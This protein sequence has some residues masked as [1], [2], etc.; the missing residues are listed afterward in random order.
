MHQNRFIRA[1]LIQ[2]GSNSPQL[3][4]KLCI[5][6][7][8]P[9]SLLRVCFIL[10]IVFAS[11]TIA[12]VRNVT[13]QASFPAQLNKSFVPTTISIGGT[14]VF[15]VTIFNPNTFQLTNAAWLD[16]LPPGLTIAN[17]PNATTDCAGGTVT[18]APGGS[19]LQLS[20]GTVPPQVSVTPGQCSVIVNVT[21][22]TPGNH[23]NT[24]PAGA[25]TSTGNGNPIT[26]TTPASATLTV[27]TVIAP[28][29]NK[30]FE[31]LT[32]MFVGQTTNLR[33][34]I[35]NVDPL[36][37][38]TNVSVT[39]NLP[40]GLTVAGPPTLSGCGGGTATTTATT[41]TLN[42]ATIAPNTT[43]DILVP[44]TSNTAGI[45]DNTIPA[46]AVTTQQGVTNANPADA[47]LNVQNVE[48]TK[49][50][51]PP[52]VL[53]GNTTTLTITLSNPT[54]TPYTGVAIT[55][56]LPA[57]VVVA[58]P[59]APSTTCG[60][61]TVSAVNGTGSVSLSGGTIPPG[62]PAA[63]GTCTVTVTV[64]VMTPGGHNNVIPAGALTTNQGAT[65]VL[66]AIEDV[67]GQATGTGAVGNKSFDPPT[68]AAGGTS[69]L[70]IT[71]TSPPDSALTNLA[72]TDNL[73]ANVTVAAFP[74]SPAPSTTCGGTVTAV[75]G[76]TTIS[77]SG[78]SMAANASC[79]IEVF[80][81]SSTPGI[82]TNTIPAGGITNAEDRSNTTPFSSDLE[83]TSGV[84]VDKV[85]TPATIGAGGTSVL[86]I[87]ITNMNT[88]PLTN[89]SIT[90]P[91]PTAGGRT[92]TVGNPANASTTCGAG[93]V[94]A[95]PGTQTVTLNGGTVPAQAGGVPGTCTISVNVVG[96]GPDGAIQNTIP[97]NSLTNAQGISN[98]QPAQATMNIAPLSIGVVKEFLPL[99]VFGG[100]AST[101]T[102]TLINPTATTLIGAAFTDTMPAG[103]IVATPLVTGTT[104][105]SGVVTA[106]V[107]AG[108]F[109]FS[110][111]NLPGG[112]ACTI[113]ISITMTVNGNLTNTIP[114]GG[115]TTLNG[116]SNPQAAAAS[117]TNLPGVSL[118]KAFTPNAIPIGG[119]SA[120]VL[121]IRNTNGFPLTDLNVTDTL[122]A[123]L[124]IAPT[125]G[126]VNTCAGTVTANPGGS[127]IQLTG[128]TV[129]IGLTCA[130][131]ANITGTTASAFTN[132]VPPGGLTSAEG[133]T[134]TT[135]ATDILT[136]GNIT[137]TPSLTPTVTPPGGSG[138]GSGSGG[139]GAGG[140]ANLQPPATVTPLP[141]P[142]PDPILADP[143]ISKTGDPSLAIPGDI[144]NWDIAVTNRGTGPAVNFVVNETLPGVLQFMS[145]SADQGTFNVNG[146]TI[147]FSVGTINPGQVIHLRIQSRVDPNA[148]PPMN[149]TNVALA[150]WLGRRLRAAANLRITRGRLPNTGERRITTP[151]PGD[152]WL[153]L[154]GLGILIIPIGY[155]G[156]LVYHRR[157]SPA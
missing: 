150:D 139:S 41:L 23:V 62:S 32:T 66:P 86:T 155:I 80:V 99:T 143:Q 24:L 132:V 105:A 48:V 18:A 8:I 33:I 121:T 63:P 11:I 141:S 75:A 153:P 90:D 27:Q 26:N 127:T 98:N 102:V 129:G 120:L 30:N 146:Q 47:T 37:T 103:M 123:G 104:C 85:F 100:S 2:G 124:T 61:G 88:F 96:T 16:N 38:L 9:R 93:T 144:V 43:C 39:D 40:G 136:I 12:P 147:T 83:V 116:A 71:I 117:L 15:T 64:R 156:Y 73:P 19:T 4:A 56:N 84:T 148:Q 49:A 140:V 133:A 113:T 109:S 72:V 20:G 119:V 42:N 76:G 97:A 54:A 51:S 131:G 142:T 57:G 74:P 70:T 95:V 118:T 68:I 35:N 135:A 44:V 60:S 81:T 110:G 28:T 78:G 3:A 114:A 45:Y 77:L 21:S 138:G 91:L 7:T 25:L 101:M 111:G 112:T 154:V 125:A 6:R 34:Q 89:T 14:S 17:P 1:I 152:G 31:P 126:I 79:V 65:N 58:N 52:S 128:G 82:H 122:P 157:R 29:I 92:I 5:K 137:P 106:T 107:G 69:R 13:A 55:D 115:V 130:I 50:F 67:D 145:A 134:N 87:T 149:I 46:S 59:P 22:T 53:V 10:A 36:N 151:P 94:T 108:S